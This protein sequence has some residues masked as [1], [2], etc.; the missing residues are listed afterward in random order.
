[1]NDYIHYTV[2]DEITYPLLNFN[3]TTIY[4]WKWINNLVP[5]FTEHVIIYPCY[6]NGP[7]MTHICVIT[8]IKKSP[9]MTIQWH[10]ILNVLKYCQWCKLRNV[11]CK[12]VAL[13][14]K[15]S[16]HTTAQHIKTLHYLSFVREHHLSLVV[17]QCARIFVNV[18]LN[19]LKSYWLSRCRGMPYLIHG[20][21]VTQEIGV[22]I[23]FVKK[24][25]DW[26]PSLTVTYISK[27]TE[28]CLKFGPF[29]TFWQMMIVLSLNITRECIRARP[30]LI[31]FADQL[32]YT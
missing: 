29:S 6:Q 7:H 2:C 9:A 16:I 24:D 17:S 25:P 8:W 4:V 13:F 28:T 19:F 18:V 21:G 22:K 11:F 23:L 3:C 30:K 31:K 1:M 10:L 26:L 27:I 5:H 20:T 15:A 12:M 32:F 14:L